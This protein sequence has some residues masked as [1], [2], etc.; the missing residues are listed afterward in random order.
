MHFFNRTKLIAMNVKQLTA[1]KLLQYCAVGVLSVS[2]L[3]VNAE[4][5]LAEPVNGNTPVNLWVDRAPLDL[6]IVELAA[7][8]GLEAVIEAPLEGQVSGVFNGKLSDTLATVG[9]QYSLLFDVDENELRA[10]P[11]SARSNASVA[12]V[13]VDLDDSAALALFD[14]LLPGN[15]VDLSGDMITVSG[16][17]SFVRRAAR[18]VASKVSLVEQPESEFTLV[19][20]P[21]SEFTL[22]LSLDLSVDRPDDLSLGD[23][24]A[25]TDTDVTDAD[26]EIDVIDAA[27][28]VVLE[29]L[30]EPSLATQQ[31]Q[32][33]SRKIEWVTDIPGFN[34]F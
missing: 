5:A 2:A 4:E 8:I 26:P 33:V 11:E 1:S 14:N 9:K 31:D 29:D 25:Q 28:Q 30:T 12:L 3:Q 22:D 21:E 13:N 15:T 10:M 19:E 7:T 24:A 27:T 20:P 32:S 16:H 6:F 18:F 34:T 23:E 17:P